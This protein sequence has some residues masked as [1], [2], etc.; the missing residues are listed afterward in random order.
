MREIAPVL[1][2]FVEK[3][4]T[5]I[6]RRLDMAEVD[7]HR[8]QGDQTLT[9]DVGL[10]RERLAVL[11]A[12]DMVPGPP[13]PPGRDGI[14]GKDGQDGK[15]GKPFEDC[16]KGVYVNGKTYEKGDVVTW[17]GSGWVCTTTTTTDRPGNG[18]TGW[19]LFTKRGRDGKDLREAP[20]GQ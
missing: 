18:Q 10:M 8:L 17:D 2:A 19:L 5:A 3:E 4:T 16:I 12:R 1:R 7:L 15:D 6:Y 11:E 9:K 14:D 13:G 20:H